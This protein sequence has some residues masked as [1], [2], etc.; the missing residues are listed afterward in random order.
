MLKAKHISKVKHDLFSERYKLRNVTM[1]LYLWIKKDFLKKCKIFSNF[2]FF[3]MLIFLNI[4][5]NLS[6]EKKNWNYQLIFILFFNVGN[7]ER[8]NVIVI[9]RQN[10][11]KANFINLIKDNLHCPNFIS[12]N[13]IDISH[14]FKF[15]KTL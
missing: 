9:N 4:F 13:F 2:S 11:E 6:N 12:K 7:K 15:N 5:S 10:L 8:Q 3:L 1:L 14:F